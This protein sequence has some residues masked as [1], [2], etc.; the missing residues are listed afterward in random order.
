MTTSLQYIGNVPDG[1][2]H[3]TIALLPNNLPSG[4]IGGNNDELPFQVVQAP[5]TVKALQGK[6]VLQL[7]TF[8][9][10]W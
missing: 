9:V 2:A 1:P 8:T 7:Q 4:T 5:G 10:S 3:V 6:N